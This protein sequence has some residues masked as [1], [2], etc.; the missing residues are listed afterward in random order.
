M[1]T[2]R[3]LIPI[4]SAA[5]PRPGRLPDRLSRA[6]ASSESSAKIRI[7]ELGA[8]DRATR[9][10]RFPQI[11]N[12]CLPRLAMP[13]TPFS[14][15]RI[16]N[17]NRRIARLV[18]PPWRTTFSALLFSR[19]PR[20]LPLPSLAEGTEGEVSQARRERS[21]SAIH[22]YFTLTATVAQ[23]RPCLTRSN[24]RRRQFSDRN[25]IAS[26]VILAFLATPALRASVSSWPSR[27]RRSSHEAKYRA[28]MLLCGFAAAAF[29]NDF[30]RSSASNSAGFAAELSISQGLNHQTLAPRRNHHGHHSSRRAVQEF[31]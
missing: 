11:S 28:T 18:R 29:P 4:P 7:G 23:S 19:H 30:R 25:K 5:Q 8:V 24:E 22:H 13:V 17:S 21:R 26:S 31:H 2:G 3:K 16:S 9:L 15:N 6:S 10:Q 14:F 12:R 20:A 1:T 27:L